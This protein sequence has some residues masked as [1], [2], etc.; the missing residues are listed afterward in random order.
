MAEQRDTSRGQSES[1]EE[2][3]SNAQDDGS[4]DRPHDDE[5]TSEEETS[6]SAEEEDPGSESEGDSEESSD[7]DDEGDSAG[8]GGGRT[9]D[10]T[11]VTAP[12]VGP[13]TVFEREPPEERLARHE[14]STEDAMGM[15]K[16][17]SV[18]GHGYGPST[19][20]QLTLYGIFLAVV[21]ALAIG[22]ALLVNALDTPVGNDVPQS[23]PWAQPDARQHNPTPLQ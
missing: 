5:E 19:A 16:R 6:S 10:H 3:P 8:D 21:V 14:Q 17:R 4:H 9:R 20:R 7:S 13:N 12:S 18:V 1:D 15:D 2:T 11:Q 22:G 23:A